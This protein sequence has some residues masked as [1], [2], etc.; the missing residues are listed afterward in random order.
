MCV[1]PTNPD[2]QKMQKIDVPKIAPKCPQ[3]S[4]FDGK[5]VWNTSGPDF[6]PYII[7]L[8]DMK[9]FQEIWIFGQNQIFRDF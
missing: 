9:H 5:W 4:H 3:I 8:T 6:R 1:E 7:I 2:G